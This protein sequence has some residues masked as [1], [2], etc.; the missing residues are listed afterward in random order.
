M[1]F[2]LH[3]SERSD[4]LADALAELLVEPLEDPFTAEV[5]AVPVLRTNAVGDG[6]A[7]RS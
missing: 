1:T 7:V 4:V 2:V 3:R 5:V 6:L